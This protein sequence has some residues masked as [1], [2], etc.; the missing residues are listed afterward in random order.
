[1]EQKSKGTEKAFLGQEAGKRGFLG[2]VLL[3]FLLVLI[4]GGGVLF[5]CALLLSFYL[6]GTAYI[7]VI[8]CSLSALLSLFGGFLSGKMQRH[9][10]ALSGFAFGI[11]YLLLLL[12]I[13]SFFGTEPSLWKKIIGYTVFLLLAVLGGI[14]GSM[15]IGKRHRHKRRRR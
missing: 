10:G 4:L 9:A 2:S 15:Q 7:G 13:G 11:L 8:G 3:S 14:L 5:V 6:G 1:M 12:V